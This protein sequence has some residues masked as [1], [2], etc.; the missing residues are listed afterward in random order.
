M[1]MNDMSEKRRDRKRKLCGQR[2][3]IMTDGCLKITLFREASTSGD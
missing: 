2:K 3:Y 1:N